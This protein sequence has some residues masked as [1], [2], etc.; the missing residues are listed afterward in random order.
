VAA[1]AAAVGGLPDLFA[2]PNGTAGSAAYKTRKANQTRNLHP[3][4]KAV[5][6]DKFRSSKFEE[7]K[8]V[9]VIDSDL[10]TAMVSERLVPALDKF[11]GH[12]GFGKN[13]E[14]V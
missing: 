1:A 13:V 6:Y 4:G 14:K 9:E 3:P 11:V 12:H 2:P 8:D 7:G 10:H 5:N